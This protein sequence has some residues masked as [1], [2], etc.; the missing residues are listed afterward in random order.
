MTREELIHEALIIVQ[1]FAAQSED[2]IGLWHSTEVL[3]G[4]IHGNTDN[5]SRHYTT[6]LIFKGFG[7]VR[8]TVDYDRRE[9]VDLLEQ[10]VMREMRAQYK[11]GC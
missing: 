9:D 6:E 2:D 5:K 1:L 10:F 8:I 11:D 3:D 7:N 4:A